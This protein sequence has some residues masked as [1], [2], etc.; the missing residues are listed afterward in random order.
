MVWRCLNIKIC[1]L[2]LAPIWYL[3][4]STVANSERCAAAP[5]VAHIGQPPRACHE[6]RLPDKS[7]TMARSSNNPWKI[8]EQSRKNP[9]NIHQNSINITH[10]S[11]VHGADPALRLAPQSH[12]LHHLAPAHEKCFVWWEGMGKSSQNHS[13]SM[14][15][16]C[17][18]YKSSKS[19]APCMLLE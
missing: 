9:S 14:Q 12:L 6:A 7:P 1:W 10:E 3:K 2:M 18:W 11:E 15:I 16:H 8:H 19:T 5:A 17:F 4:K 13:K